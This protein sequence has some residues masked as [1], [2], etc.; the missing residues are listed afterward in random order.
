ML[1][2]RTTFLISVIICLGSTLCIKAQVIDLGPD[3]T[4]CLGE[5]FKLKINAPYDDT[6]VYRYGWNFN[7]II[8]NTYLDSSEV[9][10]CPNKTTYSV[11]LSVEEKEV[12]EEG[13]TFD[14]TRKFTLIFPPIINGNNNIST[15]LDSCLQLKAPSGDYKYIWSHS[16][17]L[18]DTSLQNP[19]LCPDNSGTLEVEVAIYY[20]SLYQCV[21]KDTFFLQVDECFTT[22]TNEK[23]LD[24][25]EEINIFPN[26][27]H[28]G[29][30][31]TA[32]FN[33]SNNGLVSFAL[34]D[35]L[36]RKIDFGKKE[37]LEEKLIIDLTNMNTGIYI[38]EIQ[39][40][41]NTFFKRFSVVDDL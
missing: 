8:L 26:P 14:G 34:Y 41:N 5:C 33:N 36:G 13:E 32:K 21:Q 40:N 1:F 16:N 30:S 6:S 7:G 29:Q 10:V 19:I 38:L 12:S 22:S 4:Y 35:L 9:T 23:L 24:N 17:L 27:T 25:S 28:S 11:H 15:C 39:F 2:K 20:G 18:N 37:L 3:T 31:L